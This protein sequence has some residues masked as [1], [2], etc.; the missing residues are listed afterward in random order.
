MTL[1]KTMTVLTVDRAVQ[2]LLRRITEVTELRDSEGN[3]LGLFTPQQKADEA[4]ARR[5]FDL[6]R[7]AEVLARER[8]KGRQLKEILAEL[9]GQEAK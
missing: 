6:D 3:V 4:L 7:A 2:E 1:E 8:G 9:G 5:L